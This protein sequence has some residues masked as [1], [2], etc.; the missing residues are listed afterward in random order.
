MLGLLADILGGGL[1]VFLSAR[2]FYVLIYTPVCKVLGISLPYS[3]ASTRGSP[4]QHARTLG[5]NSDKDK[6]GQPWPPGVA[7][8]PLGPPFLPPPG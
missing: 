8:A 6:A 3:P 5:P 4:C 2:P 7:L 1:P